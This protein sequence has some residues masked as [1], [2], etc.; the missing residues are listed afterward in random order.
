MIS[1]QHIAP[2]YRPPANHLLRLILPA[3]R[4]L[5]C[6]QTCEGEETETETA[7]ITSAFGE[8]KAMLPFPIGTITLTTE[9]FVGTGTA[10]IWFKITKNDTLTSLK[11][12]SDDGHNSEELV[13]T[14]D[15]P[16]YTE[17]IEM[18]YAGSAFG[19]GLTSFRA[20]FHNIYSSNPVTETIYSEFYFRPEY[21]PA[22]E[23]TQIL[24]ANKLS[25]GVIVTN[26]GD[27]M[28]DVYEGDALLAV[29]LP[30]G[31]SVTLPTPGLLP[32]GAKIS[33]ATPPS[34]SNTVQATATRRLRCLCGDVIVVPE[35]VPVGSPLL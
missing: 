31:S 14:Y 16:P 15:L 29:E 27:L 9:E 33:P 34:Q 12:Y 17:D 18:V 13:Q 22:T 6:L 10:T 7:Q 19:P 1:T 32:I 26:T 3:L 8:T 25:D 21:I 4:Q 5:R 20:T 28:L 11:L 35:P 23:V 2:T 30:S 24:P